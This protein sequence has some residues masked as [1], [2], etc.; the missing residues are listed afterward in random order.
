[1]AAVGAERQVACQQLALGG[2]EIGELWA[3]DLLLALEEELQVD[4]QGALAL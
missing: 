3:A 2:D 4:R 1:L